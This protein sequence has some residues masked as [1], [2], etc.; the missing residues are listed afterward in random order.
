MRR[1]IAI[2]VMAVCLIC[3]G[4]VGIKMTTAASSASIKIEA[5]NQTVK[6]EQEVLVNVTVTSDVLIGKLDSIITYDDTVLEYVQTSEASQAG[7]SGTIHISDSYDS[8]TKTASYI[9]KFRA[10]EV[11]QCTVAMDE[12][13]I[14]AFDYSDVM[15][16]VSESAVVTVE[17][18]ESV[19]SDASLSQLLIAPAGMEEAFCPDIYEYHA[20]ADADVVQL[21][22]SAVPSDDQAVVTVDVPET[23]VF[24]E[25]KA[26][27]TVTALSGD[28][29]EYVIYVTRLETSSD[30]AGKTQEKETDLQPET[31]NEENDWCEDIRH[32]EAETESEDTEAFIEIEEIVPES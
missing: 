1:K 20:E 18:N 10:V 26:V 19:S 6:K 11:G 12:T 31:E 23:L 27:V 14:E 8:G 25:N 29:S 24:G 4:A 28:I 7:A 22:I 3:A 2:A 5:Q 21:M 13:V 9:L 15:E 30:D 16:A 32:E 17:K